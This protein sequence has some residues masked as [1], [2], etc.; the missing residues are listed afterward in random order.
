MSGV[1]T[2]F[3]LEYGGIDSTIQF[4]NAG[5]PLPNWVRFGIPVLLGLWYTGAVGD[6]FYVANDAG[7]P[8]PAYLGAGAPL[9]ALEK[10][11]APALDAGAPAAPAG[12]STKASSKGSSTKASST[13][14]LDAGAPAAPARTVLEKVDGS[15]RFKE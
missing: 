11:A 10:P 9:P 13:K 12:S 6:Q 15:Y 2:C 3:L 4:T 7:A 5:G 1:I 14:A 8:R